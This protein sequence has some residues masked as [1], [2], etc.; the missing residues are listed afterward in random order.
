MLSPLVMPDATSFQHHHLFRP[1]PPG[2]TLMLSASSLIGTNASSATN[3]SIQLAK[4][5]PRILVP[6]AATAS[7]GV[8]LINSNANGNG[9]ALQAD[10]GELSRT[11]CTFCLAD[12]HSW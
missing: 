4:G 11:N 12:R 7:G 1:L 2:P 5:P 3:S 6:A 9:V 10:G 8:A